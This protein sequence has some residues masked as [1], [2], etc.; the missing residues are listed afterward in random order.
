MEIK[1]D[2]FDKEFFEN[3][4][5]HKEISF[6]EDGFYHTILIDNKKA[7]VVGYIPAKFPKNSGFVQIILDLK[8]RGKGLV[9][10]AEDLLVKKYNLKILYATIKKDNITSIKAHQKIGFEIIDNKRLNELRKLGYL[11]ENE[12]RLEKLY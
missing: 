3:L 9:K 5:G 7:G 10:L 6:N 2:K 11:Q 12:I 4:D 1:L 8:F